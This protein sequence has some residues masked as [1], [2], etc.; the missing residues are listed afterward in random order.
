M[1]LPE[2]LNCPGYH[3]GVFLQ[4]WGS[5]VDV[6]WNFALSLLSRAEVF[7][8]IKAVFTKSRENSNY[9]G[10]HE[11]SHPQKYGRKFMKSIE[12]SHCP[13]YGQVKFF[14]K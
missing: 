5:F 10:Y 6:T 7:E 3:E 13:Y 8:K 9:P 4:K 11:V 12:N 2:H 14:P 1:K